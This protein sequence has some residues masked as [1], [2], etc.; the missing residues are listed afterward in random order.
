MSSAGLATRRIDKNAPLPLLFAPETTSANQT[1]LRT[2]MVSALRR[3]GHDS[4]T[5]TNGFRPPA[6]PRMAPVGVEC[7]VRPSNGG[8]R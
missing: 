1:G 4:L 2:T 6:G 3:N 8:G 5:L 7:S